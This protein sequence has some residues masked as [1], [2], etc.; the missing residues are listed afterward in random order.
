MKN[1]YLIFL[2]FVFLCIAKTIQAQSVVNGTVLSEDG[3]SISNVLVFNIDT[4]KK[5][6][7][8][9]EGKFILEGKFNEELRF[10]KDDYERKSKIIRNTSNL[11]VTL[12]KLPIEIEEVK[13]KHISGNLLTDSKRIRVDNSTEKLKKEIGIP[14][15]KGKQRE[16]VPTVVN[17]VFFP[18]LSL[19]PTIKIQELY[20][21]ISGDNRRMKALYKYEDLQENVK[22]IRERIDD[23]YFVKF[24]IP[25]ERIRE[26]LEFAIE[27]SPNILLGIKSNKIEKV[28][29]ELISSINLYT[30]RLNL[31]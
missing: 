18:L 6:Y 23:D 20:T 21:L 4:Q 25:R 19:S 26:F 16:K 10:I 8:D 1:K 3:F 9:S 13:I 24:N 11:K 12:I 28:R 31:K 5:T 30:S 27:T 7:T 29:F 22:W 15:P 17:D 14:E 2:C